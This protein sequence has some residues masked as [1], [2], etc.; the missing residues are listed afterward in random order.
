[1]AVAVS[2]SLLDVRKLLDGWVGEAFR[3]K[4]RNE[5]VKSLDAMVGS[6]CAGIAGAARRVQCRMGCCGGSV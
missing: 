4:A 6:G 3:E 2:M 5:G 1:M